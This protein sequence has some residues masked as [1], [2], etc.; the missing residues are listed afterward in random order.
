ML[1]KKSCDERTI[2]Y[3]LEESS[4]LAYFDTKELRFSVSR[5]EKGEFLRA[6]DTILDELLFVVWGTVQIYG[7]REDGR[8]SPVNLLHS[9]TIIG[10]LEFIHEGECSFFVR[11]QTDVVCLSLPIKP[12][13]EQLERDIKFLHLL[14]RS[15]AEKLQAFSSLD[16]LAS[17]TEERV[18]LYMQSSCPEH[19]LCGIDAATLQLRC[20]RRQ[21]QRALKKLCA[22]KQIEKIGRGRYRLLS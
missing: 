16:L 15:Y 7:V 10:D 14:L 1:L 22:G 18:L 4:I 8:V 17:T 21:L 2:K 19:E 20:S 11:A 6:S 9:P 3:W 5:Y 12:Y 13:R